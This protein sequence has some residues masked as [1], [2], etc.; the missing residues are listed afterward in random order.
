ML[1]M[2][3]TPRMRVK[4]EETIKRMTV[5]LKPTKIWHKTPGGQIE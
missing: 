1:G 3:S 4:P 5:R 2:R